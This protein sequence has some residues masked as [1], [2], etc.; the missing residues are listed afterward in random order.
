MSEIEIILLIT[1]TVTFLH[2]QIFF[3]FVPYLKHHKLPETESVQG[4][5]KNPAIAVYIMMDYPREVKEILF[6]T[7]C[8]IH[9]YAILVLVQL[10]HLSNSE[11][12]ETEEEMAF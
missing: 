10:G 8:F 1:G 3:C 5:Q 11:E 6:F 2:L 7:S 12:A 4:S 9:I